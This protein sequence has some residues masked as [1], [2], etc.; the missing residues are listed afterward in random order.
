M[1]IQK[2]LS[3]TQ[4]KT[5]Q[6]ILTQQNIKNKKSKK[7]KNLEA[8]NQL[9]NDR[10]KSKKEMISKTREEVITFPHK[11]HCSGFFLGMDDIVVMC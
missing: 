6:E 4:T 10:K 11:N 7:R 1:L 8:S 3:Y 5:K 2:L 9:E